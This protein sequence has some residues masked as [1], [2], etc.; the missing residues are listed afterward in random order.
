MN[1]PLRATYRLLQR[2]A[3]E[4]PVLFYSCVIGAIGPVLLVTVPPVKER[5]GYKAAEPIP[6][7]YPVPNRPRR[8]VQGYED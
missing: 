6:L 5:L 2:Q 4:F 8:P 7:S 1:N 3:H